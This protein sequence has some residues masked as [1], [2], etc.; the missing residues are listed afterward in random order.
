MVAEGCSNRFAQSTAQR[1]LV[2]ELTRRG[3]VTMVRMLLAVADAGRDIGERSF[4]KCL[5][6]ER[7]AGGGR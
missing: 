1:V 5:S 7:P 2:L 6:G 4:D 3:N